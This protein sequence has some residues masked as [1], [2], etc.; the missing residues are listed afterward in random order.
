MTCQTCGRPAENG[1]PVHWLGCK[2]IGKART[3]E[4]S[5]EIESFLEEKLAAMCEFGTCA[6]GKRAGSGK[7]AKPKYCDEHS[8]PKNRK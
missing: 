1:Q 4:E 7:G 5:A 2:E 6:N 8:D 3:P